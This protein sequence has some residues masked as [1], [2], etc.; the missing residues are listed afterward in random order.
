M[1]TCTAVCIA[2]DPLGIFRLYFYEV[3]IFSLLYHT[4]YSDVRSEGSHGRDRMV[5]GIISIKKDKIVDIK[6]RL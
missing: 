5:A 1:Y 4:I 3:L 6:F 2:S